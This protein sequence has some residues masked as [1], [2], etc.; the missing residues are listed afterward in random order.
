MKNKKVLTWLVV[1]LS[2]LGAF[3]SIYIPNSKI[4]D[5]IDETKNIVMQEIVVSEETKSEVADTKNAVENG[6]KVE[7]TQIAKATIKEEEEVTDEGA[8]ESLLESDAL[9][10]QENIAYNGDNA[11]KGLDLL[12]KWQG[13]T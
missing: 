6:G 1:V 11:G 3:A 10:E 5:V 12:G 9:V 13:L 2:V 8:D 4:N 7:T